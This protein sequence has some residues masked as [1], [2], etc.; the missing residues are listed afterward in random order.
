MYLQ[1][2][3]MHDHHAHHAMGCQYKKPTMVSHQTPLPL[4]ADCTVLISVR[5]EEPGA[6][7][8]N[9]RHA[10]WGDFQVKPVLRKECKTPRS[11]AKAARDAKELLRRGVQRDGEVGGALHLA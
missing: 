7:S 5:S 11:L 4:S 1:M 10:H 3:C 8:T 9:K 6:H 2:I